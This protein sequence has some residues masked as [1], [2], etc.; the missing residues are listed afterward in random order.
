[1]SYSQAVRLKV[2][3]Q[4]SLG[5]ASITPV[6]AGVG[7]SL[8]NPARFIMIDNLSDGDLQFSFDGVTDHFVV[9]RRS[10]KIIDVASNQAREQ[11]FYVGEGTRLYVK[12]IDAPTSGSVYFS[13]FYGASI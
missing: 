10:G 3:E 11:G 13:V 1:M 6:Y 4:R 8:E 7:S 5:F 12:E 9:A 2:E